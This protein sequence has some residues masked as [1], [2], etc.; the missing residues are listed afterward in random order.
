M[1]ITDIYPLVQS[2]KFYL[3]PTEEAR[4]DLVLKKRPR[5]PK[6]ILTGQVYAGCGWPINKATVKVLDRDYNPLVHTLTDIEGRY[7]FEN[8][9]QPG[10]YKLTAAADGYLTAR[11]TSF[12]L[13]SNNPKLINIELKSDPSADKGVVYGL[14]TDAWTKQPIMDASIIL[15]DTNRRLTAETTSNPQGQYLINRITPR[16][17]SIIARKAGYSTSSIIV[18]VEKGLLIK[19]DIQL[20]RKSGG[21]E[22]TISGLIIGESEILSD[23]C[24]GLYKVVE[25]IE[26]LIQTKTTNSEGW[27]LFTNVNCGKYLV[28][29]KLES[30]SQYYQEFLLQDD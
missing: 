14:V 1:V 30:G 15:L 16:K 25:G 22:G 17:Y 28:K 29:A 18:L 3:K 8:I 27:Y 23:A 4:V 6:T 21:L 2:K 24:V 19:S 10:W 9:L 11:T 7:S 20:F 13:H 5:D 12:I 26:T